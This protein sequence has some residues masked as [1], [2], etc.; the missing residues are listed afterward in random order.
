MP[1]DALSQRL[2]AEFVAAVRSIRSSVV[3]KA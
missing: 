1:D 3:Q 2:F